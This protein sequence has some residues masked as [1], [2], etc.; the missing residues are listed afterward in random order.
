MSIKIDLFI[1]QR[2]QGNS[3]VVSNKKDC[4]VVDPGG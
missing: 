1:N 2:T 4:Y 3:Y